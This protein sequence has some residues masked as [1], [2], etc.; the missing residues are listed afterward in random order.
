MTIAH[1]MLA[2]HPIAPEGSG[3]RDCIRVQQNGVDLCFTTARTLSRAGSA[4]SD[5]D[6]YDVE[7]V[8]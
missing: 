6:G 7:A 1:A 3:V 8:R 5:L 4:R 2:S